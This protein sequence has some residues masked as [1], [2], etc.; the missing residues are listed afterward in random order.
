MKRSGMTLL[1]G[2]ILLLPP[3]IVVAEVIKSGMDLAEAKKILEK[4]G[5]NDF[6]YL[7]NLEPPEGLNYSWF[8]FP[9]QVGLCLASKNN[10][11]EYIQTGMVNELMPDSQGDLEWTRNQHPRLAEFDL[12]KAVPTRANSDS[13]FWK[14]LGGAVVDAVGQEVSHDY[15]VVSSGPVEVTVNPGQTG[16]H[17]TI[18]DALNNTETPIYNKTIR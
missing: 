13:G 18:T 4:N 8:L 15:P 5:A 10:T 7:I 14:G 16:F 11:L 1:V 3:A 2:L 6:T 9:S 17:E 12:K